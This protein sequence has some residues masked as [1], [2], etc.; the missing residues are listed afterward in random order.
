MDDTWYKIPWRVFCIGKLGTEFYNRYKDKLGI[1]YA[2]CVSDYHSEE[3]DE[4]FEPYDYDLGLYAKE[5][6][7]FCV[8]DDPEKIL[9]Y[10]DLKLYSKEHWMLIAEFEQEIWD[11]YLENAEIKKL[12]QLFTLKFIIIHPVNNAISLIEQKF[13]QLVWDEPPAN[14]NPDFPYTLLLAMPNSIF[15]SSLESKCSA[16]YDL[17]AS[18]LFLS[19]SEAYPILV[20]P[21]ERFLGR[22]WKDRDY[23]GLVY[24]ANCASLMQMVQTATEIT[25]KIIQDNPIEDIMSVH[26]IFFHMCGSTKVIEGILEVW[27]NAFD[28]KTDIVWSDNDVRSSEIGMTVVVYRKLVEECVTR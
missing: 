1:K 7:S 20:R 9:P 19:I 26:G 24:K 25:E 3:F 13:V 16:I 17:L 6:W 22:P 14:F 12:L 5:H 21:W 4:E 27:E 8:L 15:Q 28:K 2:A 10:C 23:Y 18:A 11:K